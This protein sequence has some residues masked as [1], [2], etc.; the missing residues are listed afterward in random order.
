[1][2]KPVVPVLVSPS[3]KDGDD[4]SVPRWVGC[5]SAVLDGDV[6]EA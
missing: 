2:E 5:A 1:M 4:L 6:G 3:R